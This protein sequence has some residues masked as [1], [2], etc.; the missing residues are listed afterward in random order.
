MSD[1]ITIREL[2]KLAGVSTAT[3]SLALRDSHEVSPAT[4]E[5]VQALALEHNYRSHPAVSALMQQVRGGKRVY[6]EETIA[7]IRTGLDAGENASGPLELLAGAEKEAFRLGYRI[8]IFW[9]GYLGAKAEQLG[10]MLYHRGIRGV[11]WGPMPYPHPPL[12]FPWQHFVP[13]ACTNST[14]V[15]NLPIVSIHHTKGMSLLLEQLEQRGARSIGFLVS[16]I[17]E[18]RHDFAWR[19]GVDIYH[20]RGGKAKTQYR[21]A[22]K[23]PSEASMLAWVDEHEM[24]TLV[25]SHFF[26][27][28]THFLAERVARASLD[29]PTTD[30]GRVGG[31]YQEMGRI[32]QHAVRSM[33]VRLSNSIMGLPE[34][35]FSVVTHAVFREGVSLAPLGKKGAI[36][37]RGKITT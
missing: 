33:S 22:Q 5:K 24:D 34:N 6:D 13:I 19:G 1:R 21:T 36:E 28:Q 9:A 12:V 29:I 15:A 8:E 20:Y 26:Y 35:P 4:R 30:L 27:E 31:L 14:D 18:L 37:Q 23:M 25:V 7:F 32:G 2:A 11:I 17:E 3:V 10:R 16:E